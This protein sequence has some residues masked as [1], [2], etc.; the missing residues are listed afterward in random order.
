MNT[1]TEQS[2]WEANPLLCVDCELELVTENQIY[3][4]RTYGEPR[5]EVCFAEHKYGDSSR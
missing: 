5:C 2:P 3:G 4:N 1:R